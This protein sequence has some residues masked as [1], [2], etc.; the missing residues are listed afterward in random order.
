MLTIPILLKL[1]DR[2][3]PTC[4]TFG[5]KNAEKIA[6]LA[7][8]RFPK[9]PLPGYF[10]YNHNNRLTSKC[11][12]NALV[13]DGYRVDVVDWLSPPPRGSKY[14]LVIGH[15]PKYLS[16]FHAARAS[17]KRLLLLTGAN[18]DFGN[19]SQE[20]R[21]KLLR[22]RK[23]SY[24]SSGAKNLVTY[25]DTAVD[26]A[27]AAMLIGNEW[28]KSTYPVRTASKIG[29]IPN[30]SPFTPRIKSDLGERPQFIFFSSV[31]QVHRGLDI[32]LEA[33]YECEHQLI[34]AS[35]FLNEPDFCKIYNTELFHSKN[36]YSVGRLDTNSRTFNK[37]VSSANFCIL[38]SCSEGQSG[39]LINLMTLGLIPIATVECGVTIGNTGFTISEP[40]PDC[41]S[42]LL[43]KAASLGHDSLA[44]MRNNLFQEVLQYQPANVTRLIRAHL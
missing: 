24:L 36:I 42:H 5:S 7:Y 21:E 9:H 22:Q 44:E 29:L 16:H 15:G 35:D 1:Q 2:S 25:L 18:P 11:I 23:G 39:S 12:I 34:V 17:G 43:E 14:D 10:S 33:F 37:I 19:T 20:F 6:L 26:D 38:P 32:T 27:D 13:E 41:I 31:G 8:Q 4:V 30:V 40:T 3:L 28:T